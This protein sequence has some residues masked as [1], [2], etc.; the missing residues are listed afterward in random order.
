MS[1]SKHKFCTRKGIFLSFIIHCGCRSGSDVGSG[2]DGY[3]DGERKTKKRSNNFHLLIFVSQQRQKRAAKAKA[4]AVAK[5]RPKDR[6]RGRS[7]VRVRDTDTLPAKDTDTAEAEATKQLVTADAQRR[8]H[9]A[10][11]IACSMQ[12]ETPN[13]KLQAPNWLQLQ[14]VGSPCWGNFL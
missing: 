11:S 7:R 5:A 12:L 8:Q 3:C 10:Y 2:S 4:K 1:E 9:I 14:P 6:D 13:F